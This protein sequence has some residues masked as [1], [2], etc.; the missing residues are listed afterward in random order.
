[1]MR[2]KNNL[3]TETGWEIAENH[4][5]PAQLVTT[6]SNFLIGNG[7]LC[8]RGTF[9]EWEQDRYVACIVSDTYDM[10]DGKWRELC[11]APNGLYTR[12]TLG[13]KPVSFFQGRISEYE[14]KLNLKNGVFSRRFRWQSGEQAIEVETERFSSYDDLHL[15]PLHYRFQVQRPSEIELITGIDGQ[16]WNLNGDHFRQCLTLR[17]QDLLAVEATTV[18]KGII[19]AVVEGLRL[20]G[21][22]PETT[23]TFEEKRRILRRFRFR[24]DPGETIVLEKVMA[25][26]SSNDCEDPRKAARTAVQSALE[27]GYSKL[28]AAH[29]PAWQHFWDHADVRIDGDIEAQ[30]ALRFSLYHN[31]IAAPAHIDNLPIGARGLSCQAYQG[32][33]F[34]DQEIFNMP[35][36]LFTEP[37]VARSI[38]M[39]RYNTLDGARRKAKRLGYKGAFY[40]WISGKTG[41]ELCPSYFFKD[42]LTGRKIHNHFNDWQIHISPD[43]VYAIWE[44]Y[45]ATGDWNF[46]VNY[47]AEIA[48]EVA[49]FLASFVYFKEDKNRYE[50]IR[51]LGPDEYHE[52]VDNNA[53]TNYQGQFALQ[54]AV[55]I[56]ERMQAEHMDELAALM[57][58]LELSEDEVKTWQKMARLTYLPQ[59]NPH[60]SLLEQFDGYFQLEDTTPQEVEK[61]LLDPGEYW[62]WPNGVAVE[63]QV[64]KQADIIQLFCLHHIFGKEVM[65]VN[66]DYYAPRTQHGSSLSPSAY[67]IIAKRMGYL[68]QAYKDFIT[69]ATVDLYNTAKAVSG[70][71]F[72]GGIHTAACAGAWQVAI[73]GFG[74]LEVSEDAL[75]LDPALPME[76]Q[77]LEF[78][79]VY[80]GGLLNITIN[81]EGITLK[82]HESNP[83]ALKVKIRE[84]ALLVEPNSRKTVAYTL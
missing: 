33:A 29:E 43:I 7:Y 17:L 54:R 59:A 23:E 70:G 10:A 49:R 72:I 3:Y 46:V 15:I 24:L 55:L 13:G 84:K 78:K 51:L 34:W 73:K 32:A 9:E 80:R 31:R 41:D 4:F 63:T 25:V 61:R 5:E 30:V 28:K 35:V 21:K 14:R 38:L 81:R 39:Y 50:F 71:T 69:T 37:E 75:I 67:G 12:L 1:M 58:R 18:E 57:E 56:Y 11:N 64:I 20:S 48:F 53:F 22:A 44:Y 16:V 19:V 77:G 62:G 65:K 6:G 36:F 52:N 68:E 60:T 8:Y 27:Q 45:Q 26:Y 2:L 79:L 42:V 82:A 47:G 76:W 40:A 83:Q 74:G 66:Y